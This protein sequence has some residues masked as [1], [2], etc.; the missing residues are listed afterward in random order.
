[1]VWDEFIKPYGIAIG[2][3]NDI[4]VTDSFNELREKN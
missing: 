3:N 4:Y 2:P 1:M